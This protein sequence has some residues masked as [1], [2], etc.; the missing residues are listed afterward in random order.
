MKNTLRVCS[1]LA[2]TLLPPL[3]AGCDPG[4]PLPADD[5][6]EASAL[7]P[8]STEPLTINPIDP[9]PVLRCGLYPIT[10]FPPSFTFDGGNH[11]GWQLAGIYDSD[12][13]TRPVT[14]AAAAT[15]WDFTNFPGAL[16][17]DPAD[18][19]G[20]VVMGSHMQFGYLTPLRANGTRS[21]FWR[22]DF[23]SPTLGNGWQARRR[24]SYALLDEMSSTGAPAL[25]AQMILKV[26]NCDGTTSY[27]REVN[28]AGQPVFCQVG[29][30]GQWTTC[31]TTID[32]GS[33]VD[34]IENIMVRIFVPHGRLYEGGLYL[35]EVRAL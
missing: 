2:R 9:P 15:W 7:A 11:Q 17:G 27:F 22:E 13:T 18:L 20:S 34:R 23:V 30:N 4:A 29:Q 33:N 24:F 35:D 14:I 6:P 3:A 26:R 5:A 19:R 31:N 8:A 25:W 16:G 32:V 12:S 21:G 28:A 1:L 10:Y